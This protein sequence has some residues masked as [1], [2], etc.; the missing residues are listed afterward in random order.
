MTESNL[1]N[2]LESQRANTLWEDEASAQ[3]QMLVRNQMGQLFWVPVAETTYIRK[4]DNEEK[5]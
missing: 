3:V 1:P 2:I 5:N 4:K